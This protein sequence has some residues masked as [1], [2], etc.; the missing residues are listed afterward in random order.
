MTDLINKIRA[1]KVP[2][3]FVGTTANA[4]VAEVVANETA[5][6]VLP[7]YSESLGAPGSGADTY[8]GMMRTDIDRI[9]KGLS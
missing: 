7:L 5:A 1:E 8:L 3:V 2:A 4:K 6:K 9:E